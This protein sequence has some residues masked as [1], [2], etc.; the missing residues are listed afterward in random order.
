MPQ[1]TKSDI[2]SHEWYKHG[3]CYLRLLNN[4]LYGSGSDINRGFGKRIMVKYFESICSLYDRIAGRFNLTKGEYG[5][6]DELARDLKLDPTTVKFVVVK[7][8][9]Y[10]GW[11]QSQG[12]SRMCQSPQ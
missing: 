10:S 1:L 2:W 5:S 9:N 12:N 3:V 8:P 4:R 11:W 6:G 7:G